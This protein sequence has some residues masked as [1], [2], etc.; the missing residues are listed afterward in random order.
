MFIWLYNFFLNPNRKCSLAIPLRSISV[1]F[2]EFWFAITVLFMVYI[3][4][5]KINIRTVITELAQIDSGTI[6][7]ATK[8]HKTKQ[9]I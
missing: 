5:S 9:Q 1:C 3:D 7:K 8:T 4:C 6:D 2:S